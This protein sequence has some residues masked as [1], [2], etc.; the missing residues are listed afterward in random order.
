[1]QW[2]REISIY[3]FSITLTCSLDFSIVASQLMSK[4]LGGVFNILIHPI[5]VISN[6]TKWAWEIWIYLF[7]ITLT[8]SLDFSIVASQLMSKWPGGVFNIL[9]HPITVISNRTKWAWEISIYLFSIT[10][11]CSL[12][13]SIV[14]LQLMSKWP[15]WVIKSGCKPDLS[16][17]TEQSECEKSHQITSWFM[18]SHFGL[19]EF[20]S[21][22]FFFLRHFLI[23][24]SLSIALIGSW[25][26]S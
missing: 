8:C 15:G 16:F 22:S 13:F 18:N 2:V 21:F 11:T 17:R 5:T 12:D 10:L 9:I 25:K 14:A 20:I 4:W 1:M 24:F 7:S 26:P 6:R 23:S 3:L 19:N